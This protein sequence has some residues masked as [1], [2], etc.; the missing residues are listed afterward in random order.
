MKAEYTNPFIR[1]A[2]RTFQ[3]EL[4]LTLN[5]KSIEKKGS[6]V[7]SMPVSIIIGVT[8]P[9]RGQV[10]YSLDRDFAYQVAKHMMPGKLPVEVKKMVNSAVAEMANII[11][12]QASIDLAG[13]NRLIDLTPP[14]VISGTDLR[15]DFIKIPTVSI[16]FI[17]EY[18]ELE[19]NIAL[20]EGRNYA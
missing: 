6:T 9:V 15:V 7:P 3:K 16:S 2:V 5:R 18:G 14:A 13:E 8:G 12:G 4:N 1:G 19:I 20:Q 17:S 11:T 10:V